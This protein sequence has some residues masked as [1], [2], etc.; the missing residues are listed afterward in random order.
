MAWVSALGANPCT[1]AEL[2]FEAGDH[3]MVFGLNEA[4]GLNPMLGHVMRPADPFAGVAVCLQPGNSNIMVD[5]GNLLLL[6][7]FDDY[8]DHGD[9]G[10]MG[11]RRSLAFAQGMEDLCH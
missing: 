7:R 6:G 3:V 1:V 4:C 5:A 9:Y 8:N 2:G 10:D 11:A